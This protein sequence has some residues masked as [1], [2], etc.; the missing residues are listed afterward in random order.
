MGSIDNFMELNVSELN[1]HYVRLKEKYD[2]YKSQNLNLDMSRGKPCSEQLDLSRDMLDILKSDEDYRAKDGT[3]YLNYG[4]LDGIPEAKELFSQVLEVSTKEIIIGG[5]SSLNMMHDTIARAMLHGVYGGESPWG[6]LPVVKFL[7]PSPGYDRHFAICELFNIE[8]ITVDM[9]STG[10]DMDT[11]EKLVS[12]DDSIKGIW[13]VP[14]YSNPDGITYSDQTVDRLA[15]MNT[16]ASDFRIFWDDAYTVHHLTEKADQLKNIFAAC[17]SAGNP[18]RVLMYSSTSKITFPGSGIAMMA[19]SEENLNF[20]RKQL[21]IQTIGPDKL[22]QLRHVRFLKDMDNLKVHMEKHAAIIKPKFSMVL[23]KLESELGRKNIA[24]W[25]EPKG[26]YFIS[27]N[28]LNGCARDVINMAAEV[29]VKLT[30]AGA[31]Y[32]YGKD[33]RDRN[34]RIAPTLP[35]IEELEKAIEVLC[36][37]VQL[38]SIE[39]IL[40]EK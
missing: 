2:E 6:K 36:L 18:H 32:P 28:T 31:T 20:F 4:G 3:D 1:E 17:K 24:S 11:I 5:N 22:N 40:S 39:K 21:S 35:S 12:E 9:L 13:C 15:Q 23:N 33:P 19:A 10:P 26:G 14:K 30:K 25:N 29:G 37:C 38:V 7:C 16:K 27:L 8:M 34:I